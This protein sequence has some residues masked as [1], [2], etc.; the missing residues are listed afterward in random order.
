MQSKLAA[1]AMAAG[2]QMSAVKKHSL[3][4]GAP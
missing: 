3:H 1:A 4:E 2:T